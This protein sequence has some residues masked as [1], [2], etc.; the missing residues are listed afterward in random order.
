MPVMKNRGVKEMMMAMVDMITGGSTSLT[1]NSTLS[2]G[3]L[4][5]VNMWRWMLSTLVM[6]S[7]TTN[8]SER[9]RANRVTRLMV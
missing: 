8:P 2:M 6:G 5:P 1:A 3:P 4:L 7:S 9:I